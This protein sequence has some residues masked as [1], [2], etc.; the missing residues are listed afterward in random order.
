MRITQKEPQ[1]ILEI[2]KQDS[3]NYDS[4]G[5]LLNNLLESFQEGFP[6]RN[7]LQLV[8]SQNEESVRAGSWIL[9][10][11]GVKACEVF[12]S[13]KLLI[14]SSD[15]KVRFHYLDC[16]L[17]CATESDGDSIGKVLF[18]LE[19]EASFVR[20]RAMDILCKLDATQISS[21]LSWMES[22]DREHTV[23]YSELQL[24]RDSLHESVSFQLLEEYVKDGSPIQK[25]VTIVVAIRK[26]LEPQ[27]IVQ[28]A[29]TSKDDDAIRFC[30][31]L[32]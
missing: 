15:P 23:M 21:G 19:D 8:E 7:V 22:V 16:I 29:K 32:L 6:V 9:S 17:M 4:G 26:R 30:K 14:D 20:W 24:L 2:I 10:E 31:S 11:L 27:K 1:A 13:T 28:L 25:K 12:Q 5:N 3:W 18:L